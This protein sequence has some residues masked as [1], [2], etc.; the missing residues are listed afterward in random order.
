VIGIAGSLLFLTGIYDLE[1]LA[2]RHEIQWSCEAATGRHTLR[3]GSNTL[4][5]AP[6]LQTALVNGSPVPLNMPVTVDGGRIKLPPELSRI[7]EA[8]PLRHPVTIAKDPLKAPAPPPKEDPT[9]RI[10]AGV[11][12]AIDPGHGGMHTGGKGNGGLME[13]DI[14]L[15]VALALQKILQSWGAQVVMTRVRD[16]NFHVQVDD[17]LDSRVQIVNQA[18]PDLFLSIHTNYV[19]NT[20]P[21]GFEVWVPRC[22]GRRDHQSRDLADLLRR[23]LGEVWGNNQ[24]R[25][26]KDDHNLRVLKG[27]TCP[28]ALVELE[29]VSNP[30][31]ERQLGQAAK[32]RELATAIAEATYNWAL[33]NLR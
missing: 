12:I 23:E 22:N 4:V 32:Q 29:F 18:A 8:S 9:S 25:G 6:G 30:A 11:K 1:E 13:K 26:T 33:R 28:A 3:C 21:R 20:G 27:T 31:V 24:D 10:M 16:V 7:V 2:R 17:D 5:F 15:G 14:N 19:A